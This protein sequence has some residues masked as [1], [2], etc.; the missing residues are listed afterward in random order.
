MTIRDQI[1][2]LIRPANESDAELI[3]DLSRQ[4]FYESFA[5]DNT[6]ENMDKF[7]NEQFTREKLI[8]E[9]KLPWHFFLLAYITTEVVG[10]VKLREGLVPAQ[11]DTRSSLEIARIYSVQHMIGKGV[12]LSLIH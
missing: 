6:K 1:D 11:L 12:G 8:H 4:T 2:V 5:S 7:M 10:Y 9:V 3:A